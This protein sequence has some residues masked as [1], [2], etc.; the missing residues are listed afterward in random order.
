MSEAGVLGRSKVTNSC[1]QDPVR[2]E[3]VHSLIEALPPGPY[4]PVG[5][6][7]AW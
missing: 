5:V 1:G 4:L 2:P 7:G 6:E 3:I